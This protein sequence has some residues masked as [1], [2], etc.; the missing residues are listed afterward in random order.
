M[1]N[2]TQLLSAS[3]FIRKFCSITGLMF[4]G[5]NGVIAQADAPVSDLWPTFRNGYYNSGRSE[6]KVRPFAEVSMDRPIHEFKTGGLVWATPVIDRSGNLYFGSANKKFYSLDPQGKERWSY[7]LSDRADSLVDSAAA[8]FPSHSLVIVPGG[9]GFLH[10]LEQDTGKAR[11]TF[12]AHHSSDETHQAGTIVNSFEGNVQIG[13][14]QVIYAGSDNGYL[15]AVNP[16]GSEKWSL[17]TG[18]MIWSSPVFNRD[19]K[20]MA[21]GSLDGRLY[22]THPET[23]E[24]LAKLKAG[25]D[26]KSSPTIDEENYL[27]FGTSNGKMISAEVTSDKS[28]MHLKERWNYEVDGEIY[29]S[30]AITQDKVTVEFKTQQS[31]Q[32]WFLGKKPSVQFFLDTTTL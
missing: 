17:K 6:V 7:T 13:P 21:F 8:L 19:H 10:A 29:S 28:G 11:W 12:G 2:R 24:V 27:Y 20:W 1:F 22:V 9:D 30:P 4:F 23:G 16:D 14:N 18:M 32:D 25:G 31:I 15:Y 5:L 26:I 3:E